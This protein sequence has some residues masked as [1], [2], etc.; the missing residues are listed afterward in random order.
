MV[1]N[2]SHG[3][4]GMK[5]VLLYC[6]I[7]KESVV[8]S[9]GTSVPG[10]T[11]SVGIRGGGVTRSSPGVDWS[12]TVVRVVVSAKAPLSGVLDSPPSTVPGCGKSVGIVSPPIDD[13]VVS[14]PRVVSSPVGAAVVAADSPSPA[15]VVA[16]SPVVASPPPTVLASVPSPLIAVVASP[17]GTPLV[18]PPS[19]L[20]VV[21]STGTDN[22]DSP[23]A[24]NVVASV[25]CVSPAVSPP[26]VC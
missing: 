26:V 7:T 4:P 25:L 22:V 10:V 15:A 24:G 11:K 3:I 2:E 13:E 5:S 9:A 21:M 16:V 17:P 14:P 8:V 6:P 1:C 20:A 18:S 12:V 19:A 23:I